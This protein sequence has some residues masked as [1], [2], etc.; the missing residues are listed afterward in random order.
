MDQC[1]CAALSRLN[2]H[3]YVT[4]TLFVPQFRTCEEANL[5]TLLENVSLS[6]QKLSLQK[7][8]EKTPYSTGNCLI[9]NEFTFWKLCCRSVCHT[10][11]HSYV[12]V[13]VASAVDFNVSLSSADGQKYLLRKLVRHRDSFPKSGSRDQILQ[14]IQKS[15]K[16]LGVC[17]TVADV[18]NTR[19]KLK[20]QYSRLCREGK[21]SYPL[22]NILK[23]AFEGGDLSLV[24]GTDYDPDID[25][26]D[27]EE[28]LNIQES[29]MKDELAK[30]CKG[31][32]R[33]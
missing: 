14:L 29:E 32:Q 25:P 24:K 21:S 19:K 3:I 4:I 1:A 5:S 12:F 30:Y 20:D 22:Y 7:Y 13:A 27:E 31:G 26:P 6:G 33:H 11:H 16:H 9:L 8:L 18:R 23:V 17:A 2:V 28:R 15:L 10:D